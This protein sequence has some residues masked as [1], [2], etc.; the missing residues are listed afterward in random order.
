MYAFSTHSVRIH[1]AF[2]TRSVRVQYAFTSRG[3]RDK[4]DGFPVP[5]DGKRGEKMSEP[6]IT[7]ITQ[8]TQIKGLED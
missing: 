1:Y 6:Q 8:I 5:G 2:S 3:E 7:Q 4:G